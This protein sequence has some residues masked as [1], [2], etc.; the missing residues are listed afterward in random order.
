MLTVPK[1]CTLHKFRTREE[2]LQSRSRGI[3]GTDAATI[4]GCNPYQT[5]LELFS[6]LSGI[7]IAPKKDNA[8]MQRGRG[9][10]DPIRKA[11]EVDRPEFRVYA[12]PRGGN[13]SFE[14]VDKP[15]LRASLDGLLRRKSD[16]ALGVLEIKTVGRGVDLSEWDGKIPDHYYAQVMH[17]CLVLHAKFAIL[18][19]R[20]EKFDPITNQ[21]YWETRDYTIDCG[22]RAEELKAL[23]MAEDAFWNKV[24]KRIPPSIKF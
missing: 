12:P 1:G 17:Y 13:W 22:E 24:Q 14:R 11:F 6:R 4:L 5:E 21:S 15:Y 20:I 19:A 8:S 10:E 23:E 2:W 16:R 18:R 7:E 9:L 3:G